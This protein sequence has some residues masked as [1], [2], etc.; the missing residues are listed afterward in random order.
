M[1]KV[2]GFDEQIQ[3]RLDYELNM[4]RNTE[5]AFHFLILKEIADCSKENGYSIMPA[6][7]INDSLISYLLGLTDINPLDPAHGEID[8]QLL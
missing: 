4:M 1:Q 5:T 7:D 8:A 6:S 2:F 3:Q